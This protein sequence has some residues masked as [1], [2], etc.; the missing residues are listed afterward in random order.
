MP[1]SKGRKPKKSAAKRPHPNRAVPKKNV[2]PKAESIQ[3][4][5]DAERFSRDPAKPLPADTLYKAPVDLPEAATEEQL[6]VALFNLDPLA[7]EVMIAERLAAM[8]NPGDPEKGNPVHIE[9]VCRGPWAHN[10]R[11]LG[12][13]CI[14]ELATHELIAPD[15]ASGVMVNHTAQST[16]SR[17]TREDLWEKAKAQ[18]PE[19]AQLVENAKTPEE[20]EAAAAKLL[21][22]MPMHIQLAAKRLMRHTDDE[23]RLT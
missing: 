22:G 9:R 14:P 8:P 5:P 16:R 7:Q 6:L 17:M 15:R 18:N 10:L 23:L 2:V 20:R 13:F 12:I 21:K 11:K 4:L 1:Q 3:D 19:I